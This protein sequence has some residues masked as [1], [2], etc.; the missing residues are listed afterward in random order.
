MGIRIDKLP[1]Q[2]T[3]DPPPSELERRSVPLAITPASAQRPAENPNQTTTPN[4]AETNPSPPSPAK[5]SN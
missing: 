2:V 1:P 3:Q 4:E 5:Q